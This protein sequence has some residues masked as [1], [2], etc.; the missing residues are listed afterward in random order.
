M[1]SELPDYKKDSDM[2]D[3]C[4]KNPNDTKCL[5]IIYNKKK[6]DTSNNQKHNTNHNYTSNYPYFCWYSPC[7]HPD[8]YYVPSYIKMYQKYCQEINCSTKIKKLKIN[9]TKIHIENK[10]GYTINDISNTDE[11]TNTYDIEQSN[12][13]FSY[14]LWLIVFVLMFF[15]IFI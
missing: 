11:F 7:L 14:D 15:L 2:I 5:C 6:L 9:K 13:V 3:F 8:N 1:T 4:N 12:N 10:C